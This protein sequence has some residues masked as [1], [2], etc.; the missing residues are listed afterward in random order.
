MNFE[1]QPWR[2]LANC[3]GV[4][5]DLFFPERGQSTDE[6]KAVCA[7]CEV[8]VECLEFALVH[9]EKF[10]I[11]GGASE[12]ERRRMRKAR[13]HLAIEAGEAA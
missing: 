13:R 7:G 11:W 8:R 6:A 4:D 1:D 10:G 9:G 2:M 3:N 5:P 12:R